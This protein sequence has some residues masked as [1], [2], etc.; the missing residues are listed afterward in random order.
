VRDEE[1][2]KKKRKTKKEANS[3]KLGI[4]RD[5][6]RLPIKIKFFVVGGGSK[7]RISSKSVKRFRSCEGRHLPMLIDL[8]IRLYNSLHYRTGRDVIP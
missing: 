7:V 6:P 2:M 1:I 3:G 4:R 8:A 5:R